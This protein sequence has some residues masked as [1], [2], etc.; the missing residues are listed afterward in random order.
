MTLQTGYEGMYDGLPK[1]KCVQKREE[2]NESECGCGK[3]PTVDGWVR[4]LSV[5]FSARGSLFWIQIL[6]S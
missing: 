2:I 4:E 3:P 6:Q 1:D 5:F